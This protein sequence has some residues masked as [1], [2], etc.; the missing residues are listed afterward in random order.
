[1][2]FERQPRSLDSVDHRPSPF[3]YLRRYAVLAQ[4]G[5][6]PTH[7]HRRSQRGGLGG[8]APPPKGV[9]KNCTAVLAV[10]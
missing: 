5:I 8:L 10:Q 7:W 3:T 2:L 9:E 1:M 6:E 4:R